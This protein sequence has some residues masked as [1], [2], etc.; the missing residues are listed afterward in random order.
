MD[1]A[2]TILLYTG[3]VVVFAFYMIAGMAI[4]D[5]ADTAYRELFRWYDTHTNFQK[6]AI[7]SIWPVVLLVWFF[8]STWGRE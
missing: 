5:A 4:L 3:T 1:I 6:L 7:L 8:Y 2:L